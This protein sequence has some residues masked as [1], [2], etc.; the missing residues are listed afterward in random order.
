MRTPPRNLPAAD[1]IARYIQAGTP[2]LT[3]IPEAES[4]RTMD[5][6]LPESCPVISP[7]HVEAA[8]SGSRPE[9]VFPVLR[10]SPIRIW[11]ILFV[12]DSSELPEVSAL[13]K[14]SIEAFRLYCRRN[15]REERPL[16][17]ENVRRKQD[18]FPCIAVLANNA[19][20]RPNLETMRKLD[21]VSFPLMLTLDA[22]IP[23]RQ[24]VGEFDVHAIREFLERVPSW[25]DEQF[26]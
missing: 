8:F 3:G 9:E 17:V 4:I 14:E 5:L 24:H 25:K 10:D 7:A 12:F 19:K 2:A 6:L 15:L 18:L 20:F 1:K 16:A 11:W 13:A 21:I 26:T 23:T 22:G